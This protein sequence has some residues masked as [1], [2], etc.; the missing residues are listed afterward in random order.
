MNNWSDAERTVE[1]DDEA[2]VAPDHEESIYAGQTAVASDEW[3][4]EDRPPHW[5]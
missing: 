1:F 2:L 4:R 5:E 3:L